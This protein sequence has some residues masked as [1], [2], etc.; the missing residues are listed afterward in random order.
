MAS[1]ST[2][3]WNCNAVTQDVINVAGTLTLPAVATV[4]VSEETFGDIGLA[5]RVLVTFAS[6]PAPMLLANWTVVGAPPG[7]SVRVGNNQVYLTRPGGTMI[8]IF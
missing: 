1:N 5:P 8:S 2:L 3:F 6:G 4:I 7:T